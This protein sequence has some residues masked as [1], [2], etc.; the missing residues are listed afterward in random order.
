MFCFRSLPSREPVPLAVSQ[1]TV[2]PTSPV[3][4]TIPSTPPMVPPL[5]IR[6]RPKARLVSTMIVQRS[7]A[8]NIPSVSLT[9][10][11]TRDVKSPPAVSQ[12]PQDDSAVSRHL[13]A[14]AAQSATNATAAEQ[15]SLRTTMTDTSTAATSSVCANP[16]L[17][18]SPQ[19]LK[20]QIDPLIDTAYS[21]KRPRTSPDAAVPTTSST[22]IGSSPTHRMACSPSH[23]VGGSPTHR[24]VTSPQHVGASPPHRVGAS[25]P[26]RVSASPQR[27]GASPPHRVGASPPQR[28]G[29]MGVSPPHLVGVS[30]PHRVSA[31]P[32]H[33]AIHTRPQVAQQVSPQAMRTL[34]HLRSQQPVRM[35]AQGQ[36]RTLAQIKAQMKAKRAEHAN[37][38]GRHTPNIL[39]P[40]PTVIT[41]PATPPT[42]PASM[43][44]V[45]LA[46]SYALCK[47]K[48]DKMFQGA[49]SAQSVIP[50]MTSSVLP[51]TNYVSPF[52]T[53]DVRDTVPDI[54]LL[55]SPSHRETHDTAT[56]PTQVIRI[57]HAKSSPSAAPALQ[58]RP[59]SQPPEVSHV[60]EGPDNRLKFI[61][62]P[63]PESRL[64]QSQPSPVEV[65]Q[66]PI[67]TLIVT[68]SQ[69]SNYS[70]APSSSP[71]PVRI[72]PPVSVA[73]ST[74]SPVRTRPPVSVTEPSTQLVN[75]S[76][77][78]T[79][80]PQLV[81]RPEPTPS[82]P[83]QHNTNSK[84][85]VY[86][87]PS[88][89]RNTIKLLR[90][91]S[92]GGE[93]HFLLSTPDKSNLLNGEDRP[94]SVAT[95]GSEKTTIPPRASS[96]PPVELPNG[97]VKTIL[98][99]RPSASQ[100]GPN[101]TLPVM[102]GGMNQ[103]SA[104]QPPV[105][106][107]AEREPQRRF[108]V[109]GTFT[110]PPPGSGAFTGPSPPPPLSNVVL[111][112]P[113][114]AI[115]PPTSPVQQPMVTRIA[116]VNSSPHVTPPPS[117]PQQQTTNPT[118]AFLSQETA[119][120]HLAAKYTE[121]LMAACNRHSSPSLQSALLH[122][123]QAA[124]VSCL[125]SQAGGDNCACSRKA[126][127]TCK[128]C[129]AFCHDDC[130]GPTKLCVS[131]LITI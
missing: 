25:P 91:N 127:V 131:C 39:T 18:A 122:Q 117:S 100:F 41:K 24:M 124:L 36:T 112:P 77:S 80:Q 31:S 70:C 104:S 44:G 59:P 68:S 129:G 38:A 116:L 20:R 87:P 40:K 64:R 45:N 69:G 32:P 50:A 4:K 108:R 33:A 19:Q 75:I 79:I 6:A 115:Q 60:I 111:M 94:S 73:E 81:P 53:G 7:V 55:P 22:R 57:S 43:E 102:G 97:A 28:L 15:A 103:W 5:K 86:G 72:R 119:E 118:L 21:I 29:M 63:S 51:E 126:M 49:D 82:P 35:P 66:P 12:S 54:P 128:K 101:G 99:Q 13:L 11:I 89:P 110:G 61:L 114:S 16:P 113:A 106:R 3:A 105:E 107:T 84:V 47:Q 27:V 93:T 95:V 37:V 120:N 56:K 52:M 83:L 8:S 85:V 10:S 78:T 9:E 42:P 2:L 67:Q 34:A 96:A 109:V 92:P 74:P 125:S 123:Q 65:S 62:A 130:I 71:S 1:P 48:I 17:T 30:P 121:G 58:P 14:L 23:R 76:Q 46:L 90:V 88:Q 26:Q 98:I